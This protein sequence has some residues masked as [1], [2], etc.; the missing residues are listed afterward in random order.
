MQT[1][2]V[3]VCN[4]GLFGE[5]VR[6]FWVGD[7]NNLQDQFPF[8]GIPH[9]Q[10]YYALILAEASE[11]EILVDNHR[12][13]LH[14]TK[15]IF[16]KPRCITCFDINQRTAGK[17]ICF[18]ED[19]F[20]LRYNNNILHQ[21][22][23]LQ[24]DTVP[25]A[26]LTEVQHSKCNL[27]VTLL[28]NEFETKRRESHKVLRSYLNIILFEFERYIGTSTMLNLNTIRQQKIHEFEILIEKHFEQTKLPSAYASKLHVSPNYLNKI[29]KEETGLTAG[30]FIRKRI[31]IEAQRML[32]FTSYSVGEI[33]DKLG[34]ENASYFITFFKKQTGQTPEQYR[35][36][37]S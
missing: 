4:I 10:D 12:I 11:G 36:N 16:I 14:T 24:R 37:Q 34:F 8:L 28:I 5:S 33:A 23:F 3:A 1:D 7:L 2:H 13:G 26:R 31:R 21:F 9:R 22:S 17:V 32:I 20:S 30:D 35:K 18:T 25:F 27:L 15:A 19:F 6:H 29:C